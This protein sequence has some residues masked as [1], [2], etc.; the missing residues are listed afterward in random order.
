[1]AFQQERNGLPGLIVYRYCLLYI[2]RPASL[3]LLYTLKQEEVKKS[4][5]R[6]PSDPLTFQAKP[7]T[8]QPD[9]TESDGP[10]GIKRGRPGCL[11]QNRMG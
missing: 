7:K 2:M 3:I 4:H 5:K 9:E 1:M 8:G 10:S 11:K 6:G